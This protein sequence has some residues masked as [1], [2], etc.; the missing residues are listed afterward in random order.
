MLGSQRFSTITKNARIEFYLK[1]GIFIPYGNRC[2]QTHFNEANLLNNHELANIKESYSST[3]FD[4]DQINRFLKELR[5][6]YL[7]TA[8]TFARFEDIL[9]VTNQLCY[10]FTGFTKDEFF[11]I[12]NELKSL[13]NSPERT[14][15]QALVIFLTWLKTGITQTNLAIF[16]GIEKRQCISDYCDQVRRAFEKDFVDKFLG[17]NHLT[18]DQWLEKNTILVKELYNLNDDQLSLIADGTYIYCQK[19][20][21]NKI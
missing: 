10:D 20:A 5:D 4:S 14:K 12:L 19:S 21:N 13:N 1:S 17:A 16:F 2:C 6:Y 7:S 9:L 3:D 15:G 8:T 18:R 11:F